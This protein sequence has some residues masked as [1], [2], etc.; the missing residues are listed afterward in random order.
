MRD[1]EAFVDDYDCPYVTPSDQPCVWP[2]PRELN[3]S[4]RSKTL[5]AG[6]VPS[7]CYLI[8]R[9][10]SKSSRMPSAKVRN[11][12]DL[13]ESNNVKL[14]KQI[15]FIPTGSSGSPQDQEMYGRIA[16]CAPLLG[17]NANFRETQIVSPI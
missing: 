2:H 15:A 8:V 10:V 16:V 6:L 1:P 13:L 11:T 4:Q 7:L 17:E 9:A 12:R 5:S 14:K 3:L